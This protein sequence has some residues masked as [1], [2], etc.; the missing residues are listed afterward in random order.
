MKYDEQLKTSAWMRTKY[1][2]LKRD[3]FVCSKCLCDNSE[4]QLEVH[5]IFYFKDKSVMA[6]EY[7]D[8]Y[9]VTLCRDCHQKEHDDNNIHKFNEIMRWVKKLF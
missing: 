5:H 7:P 2:I 3:N 1:E 6:W 8:F 4:S 9:L